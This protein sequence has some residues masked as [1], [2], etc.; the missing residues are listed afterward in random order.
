MKPT[1]TKVIESFLKRGGLALPLA[2]LA[3]STPA[4][5]ETL[6][7]MH[8]YVFSLGDQSA[9]VYYQTAGNTY[10]VVTTVTPTFIEDE[11]RM[12]FVTLLT[13]GQKGHIALT[14]NTHPTDLY[15]LEMKRDGNKVSVWASQQKRGIR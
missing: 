4:F 7:P 13:P 8:A 12:Q 10:E 11:E 2:A 3:A 5:A 15:I 14:G 9:V 1:F 6:Q